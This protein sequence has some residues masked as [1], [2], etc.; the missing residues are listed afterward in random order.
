MTDETIT[1]V[2]V[3]PK[4][5]VED[6]SQCKSSDGVT[7]FKEL[8]N[9]KEKSY[10]PNVANA[11]NGLFDNLER[12]KAMIDQ[13]DDILEAVEEGNRVIFVYLDVA[14]ENKDYVSHGK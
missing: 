12:N 1:V 4:L 9:L 2:F 11:V 10:F 5:S 14:T 8:S 7:C 6:L 3:E 13:S